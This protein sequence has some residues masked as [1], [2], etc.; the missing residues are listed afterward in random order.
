VE[1]TKYQ[2]L[3]ERLQQAQERVKEVEES[4]ETLR[5][6]FHAIDFDMGIT[7]KG[8]LY[9]LGVR[10]DA[11]THANLILITFSLTSFY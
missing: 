7:R 10:T 4:R 2:S 1:K 9:M 6:M 5:Q 11:P 3:V 8:K